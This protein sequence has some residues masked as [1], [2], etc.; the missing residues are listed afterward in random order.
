MENG[1]HYLISFAIFP[2]YQIR[3]NLKL[4][5]QVDCN[6]QV[7]CGRN[8][9]TKAEKK[10]QIGKYK[11]RCE[12]T[13]LLTPRSRV[14][15]GKLTGSAASQEI[16]RILRKPKVHHRTH[17]CPPPVPILSQVHPVPKV[18][19]NFLKIPLNI[20]LPSTSGSPQCENTYILKILI[21]Y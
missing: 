3:L 12:N 1:T 9:E 15:L 8:G 5:N 13:Y 6:G 11:R 21:L 16:P 17:K 14:L 10:N 18:P 7:T 19:S 2:F 20:I 4:L